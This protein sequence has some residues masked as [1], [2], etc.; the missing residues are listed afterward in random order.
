MLDTLFGT[1]PEL[2]VVSEENNDC[3]PPAALREDFGLEYDKVIFAGE[4]YKIIEDGAATEININ[5]TNSINQFSESVQRAKIEFSDFITK[6]FSG[7]KVVTWPTVEFNADKYWLNRGKSFRNC[8]RF[9]C[10]PDL[11]IRTGELCRETNVE[12]YKYRHGGGHIHISSPRNCPDL[13]ETTYFDTALLLD[14][15][16]GTLC[17]AFDKSDNNVDYDN[18][19]RLRL[20]Y[21]GKPGKIRL[22]KYPHGYRGIEYRSPSNYWTNSI[23]KTKAVLYM[24]NSVYKIITDFDLSGYF[25][26]NINFMLTSVANAILDYDKSFAASIVF[27]K[28]EDLYAKNV[29]SMEEAALISEEL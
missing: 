1:D 21:Y 22:Q 27:R 23:N 14:T 16:V 24:A 6:N 2:F 10:D 8:V 29:L 11:D 20:N 12:T 25:L 7:L 26:Q 13:F 5:P 18:L 4:D 9:G 19:E 15:F 3:I 17:V 28:L